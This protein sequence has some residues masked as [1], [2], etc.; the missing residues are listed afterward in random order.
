MD[1]KSFLL[2]SDNLQ[3]SEP[4]L[5]SDLALSLPSVTPFL[6]ASLSANTRQAYR[7]DIAHFT[8][9]GGSIPAT[10]PR[11]S[12]EAVAAIIKERA[13]AVG[14]THSRYSD[15]SLRAGLAT[16]AA[17]AGV[18]AWKI[19]QQTEHASDAMLTRYIQDGEL[20]RDNAAGALL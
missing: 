11:S 12:S 7:H 14:L 6:A 2:T 10:P 16:S 8:N 18:A 4:N 1:T 13:R 5:S 3:L 15:H 20:F 9:W 17:M 19:R